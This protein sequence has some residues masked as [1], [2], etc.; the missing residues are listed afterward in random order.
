MNIWFVGLAL[1]LL[2]ARFDSIHVCANTFKTDD[3]YGDCVNVLH[4]YRLLISATSRN[5]VYVLGSCSCLQTSAVTKFNSLLGDTEA[6][7]F[8]R[9]PKAIMN[10]IISVLV[11]LIS[12]RWLIKIKWLVLSIATNSHFLRFAQ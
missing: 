11:S 10:A 6:L 12:A 8:R 3:K 9:S 5:S 1:I 2:L 4:G 7:R